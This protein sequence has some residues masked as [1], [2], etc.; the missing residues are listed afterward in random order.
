MI[1]LD[2]DI[3][4]LLQQGRPTVVQRMQTCSDEIAITIV[5][6]SEVI[7]GRLSALFKAG[8]SADVKRATKLLLES[9]EF[10]SIFSRI[11]FNEEALQWVDRRRTDKATRKIRLKDLLIASIAL[12]HD[13]TLVTRNTKDFANIP[14]LKLPNWAE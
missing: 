12:A 3:L 2:T 7:E 13:A 4:T 5:N 14:N 10:L 6:Y 11:L 1:I 8:A 9:K